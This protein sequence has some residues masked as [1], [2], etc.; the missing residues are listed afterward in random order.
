MG[1]GTREAPTSE[2]EKGAHGKVWMALPVAVLPVP[3]IT[4]PGVAYKRSTP[5]TRAD[6]WLAD[7]GSAPSG[8]TAEQH[9]GRKGECL[10]RKET[11]LSFNLLVSLGPAKNKIR[12]LWHTEKQTCRMAAKGGWGGWVGENWGRIFRKKKPH[13]QWNKAKEGF[14][15]GPRHAMWHLANLCNRPRQPK[16]LTRPTDCVL[17]L[18]ILWF[19]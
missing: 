12:E 7:T 6:S 10:K 15:E 18:S 13:S 16:R 11:V 19:N 9:E 17:F 2:R 8:G 1:V 4:G 14:V 5:N 3:G